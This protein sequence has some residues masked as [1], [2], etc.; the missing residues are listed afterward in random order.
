MRREILFYSLF[1][2]VVLS[3]CSKTDVLATEETS[4]L[5]RFALPV[6]RA[7]INSAAELNQQ[8]N[9]FAVWGD[10]SSVDSSGQTGC[11]RIFTNDAVTYNGVGWNY[12]GEARY[13]YLGYIYNFYA[14]YP[15]VL[16]LGSSADVDTDG[17]ITVSGFDCSA[18]GKQ[19][20]D[21]MTSSQTGIMYAEGDSPQPVRMN[22][23]H[24]LARLNFVVQTEESTAYVT[25]ANLTG[26]AYKGILKRNG[27]NAFW[28]SLEL[29]PEGLFGHSTE[30]EVDL[31]GTAL[32]DEMLLPAQSITA[33]QVSL[34]VSYHY[35]TLNEEYTKTIILPAIT[36]ESGN[37]YTYTLTIE[38]DGRIHFEAPAIDKWDEAL[39]GIIIVD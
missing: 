9:S 8:G 15:A 4:D 23:R 1:L 21:L 17:T 22:F 5:L 16:P 11:Y 24:E 13:W 18:M 29:A 38:S 19:A 20:V 25:K 7:A 35:L 10:Y 28:E 39:G 6:T 32:L 14:V 12:A 31:K 2:L 37:S 30:I 26:V 33:N 3:A 34:S 27:E 36:W